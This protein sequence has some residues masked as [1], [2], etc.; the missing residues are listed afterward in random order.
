[1]KRILIVCISFFLLIVFSCKKYNEVNDNL[2]G[3][4]FIRGRVFIDN[5]INGSNLNPSKSNVVVKISIDNTGDNFMYSLSSDSEGYFMFKNL[6]KEIK[7]SVFAEVTIDSIVYTNR[8]EVYAGND[9]FVLLLSPKNTEQS[10][11]KYEIVGPNDE[12]VLGCNLCM[13]NNALQAV[14]TNCVGSYWT[15]SSN[16]YGVAYKVNLPEGTYYTNFKI[17][18]NNVNYL[19]KDTIHIFKEGIITKRVKLLP[20]IE[21]KIA[22]KITDSLGNIVSN[23]S[24]CGFTSSILSNDSCLNAN[25]SINSLANG[26]AS[27]SKIPTGNYYVFFKIKVGNNT[28]YSNDTIYNFT[29]ITIYEK[30]ITLKKK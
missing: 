24:V 13:Y 1:M 12:P 9:S 11:L 17:K 15:T 27:V 4:D 28:Y 23:C 26:I 19:L 21:N 3:N 10:I 25:W 6:S 30:T 8:C 7:Y 20:S 14:D 2:K 18:Y 16:K 29:N 22:Y 5:S